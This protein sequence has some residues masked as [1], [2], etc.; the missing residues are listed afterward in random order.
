M[1][2]KIVFL[3]FDGVLHGANTAI[4]GN[5]PHFEAFFQQSE[6]A[7]FQVVISSSW[8]RGK[9]IIGLRQYFSPM[10]SSRIVGKTPLLSSF[11]S[12]E[13]ECLAWLEQNYCPTALWIALDD[14]A[15]F[16]PE[17]PEH[18]YLC[19]PVTGFT[20][21]DFQPLAAQILSLSTL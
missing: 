15:A 6:F 8:R 9:D 21:K 16:F 19:N 3:D 11:G 17:H 1:I 20:Q 10:F 14:I 4:F 12:R 2:E 13:D 5:I 18:L 7:D